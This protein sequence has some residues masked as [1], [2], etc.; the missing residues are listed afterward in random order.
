MVYLNKFKGFICLL[1]NDKLDNETKIMKFTNL[2]K[3]IDFFMGELQ[4]QKELVLMQYFKVIKLVLKL[5]V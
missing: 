5:V 1:D 3:D 2:L 4:K